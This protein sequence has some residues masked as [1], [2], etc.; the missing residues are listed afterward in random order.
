MKNKNLLFIIL[1]FLPV[2][3]LLTFYFISKSHEND[4][5]IYN[6]YSTEMVVKIDDEEY[7]IKPK[8]EFNVSLE[9]GKHKVYS[10]CDKVLVNAEIDID[11][12]IVKNG[13]FLNL[14][15]QPVYLWT[16]IYKNLT[17]Q[18]IA[19]EVLHNDTIEIES[20]Y[21]DLQLD[22]I[23]VDSYKIVGPIKE[24]SAK[25]LLIEKQWYYSISK[26]FQDEIL[27]TSGQSINIQKDVS[28]LFSKEDLI[29]Y[30]IELVN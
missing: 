6:P 18:E 22:T 20:P 26:P 21:K 23:I 27:N 9:L 19:K 7:I 11:N 17:D 28:K 24:F 13:G 16:S 30:W 5:I 15:N 29:N 14:S 12:N 2:I 10:Y 25:E 3:L 4:I 1:A 8:E